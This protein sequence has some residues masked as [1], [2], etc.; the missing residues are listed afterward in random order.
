M[1][2]IFSAL[3]I[4]SFS[5]TSYSQKE[6]KVE[7]AKEHIG[8][9]VKVCTKIFDANYEENTKGSPT[10]LY[11]TAHNP[12]TTLTFI[13]WGEKRKFF[14]Y[15]PEKDLKER[16]VCVTGK[17]ELFKDKPVIVIDKQSQVDIK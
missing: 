5:V 13:I 16:E 8:D 10:Y 11:T 7:E 2:Q 3:L 6:I 17:L 14:D 12:N 1:K 15:K 9:S 4:L